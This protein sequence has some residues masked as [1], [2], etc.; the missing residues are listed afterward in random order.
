MNQRQDTLLIQA[1]Q[2]LRQP[3]CATDA[4]DKQHYFK[5]APGEYAED[6][7]KYISTALPTRCT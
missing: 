3:A 7:K 6:D 1:K 4:K 5:T 2:V